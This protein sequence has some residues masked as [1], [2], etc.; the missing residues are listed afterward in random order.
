[1]S[2]VQCLLR[3]WLTFREISAVTS[4]TAQYTFTTSKQEGAILIPG[5][6]IEVADVLEDHAYIRYMVENAA[7]WLEFATKKNNRNI[8]LIDLVLVTGWDKTTSWACVAFSQRS[9]EMN[10]TFDIGAGTMQGGAWGRWS[11]IVFPGVYA[12]S[13]PVRA[14]VKDDRP[15]QPPS[16]KSPMNADIKLYVFIHQLLTYEN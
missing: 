16:D 10:L 3:L 14:S 12:H 6:D 9:R 4:T 2:V 11:N 8:R 13:G 15:S 1:M 5:G 7:S